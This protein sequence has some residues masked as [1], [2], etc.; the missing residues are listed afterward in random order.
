MC[1]DAR[2]QVPVV[3]VTEPPPD[4]SIVNPVGSKFFFQVGFGCL[5]FD[6]ILLDACLLELSFIVL[7]FYQWK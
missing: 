1:N 5:L 6:S 3:V 7:E 2:Y 4:E